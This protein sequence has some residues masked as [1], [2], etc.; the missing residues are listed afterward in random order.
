MNP[1][2]YAPLFAVGLLV[3]TFA[4]LESGRRTGLRHLARHGEK[5]NAGLG[6]VE[7][8]IFGLLGLLIAFSFQARCHDST[9]VGS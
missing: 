9:R 6:V 4:L 5:A 3:G 7:G 2:F 8:A 1:E